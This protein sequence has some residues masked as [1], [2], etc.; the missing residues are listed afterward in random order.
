MK[1]T[2]ATDTLPVSHTRTR[3]AVCLDG[4]LNGVIE[5]SRFVPQSSHTPAAGAAR[6]RAAQNTVRKLK[7]RLISRPLSKSVSDSGVMCAMMVTMLIAVIGGLQFGL[8]VRQLN[9]AATVSAVAVLSLFAA[10]DE[11][12]FRRQAETQPG[13][14][15]RV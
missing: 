10:A 11:F 9:I 6:V 3:S 14:R 12:R 8:E 13:Q 4:W 5:V 15:T 1:R 2:H 7:F